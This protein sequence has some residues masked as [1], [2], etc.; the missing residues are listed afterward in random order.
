M[1]CDHIVASKEARFVPAFIR[2]GL[3]PDGGASFLISQRV[4][5]TR[6][7]GIL[8]SGKTISAAYALS[9]G[10]IDEVVEANEVLDTARKWASLHLEYSLDAMKATKELVSQ[11]EEFGLALA[12]EVR[13]QSTLV[14]SPEHLEARKSFLSSKKSKRP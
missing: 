6:A 1:A 4:G 14:N 10:L 2:L 13:E 12:A 7:R 11:A 5:K 3:A 9:M 8:L